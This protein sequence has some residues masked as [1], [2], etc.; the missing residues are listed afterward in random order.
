M[1]KSYLLNKGLLSL[2]LVVQKNDEG[3]FKVLRKSLIKILGV[4]INSPI[5]I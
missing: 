5:K 3:T 1:K 4:V 2:L